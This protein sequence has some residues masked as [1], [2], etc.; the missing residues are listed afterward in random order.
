MLSPYHDH[1]TIDAPPHPMDEI[2]PMV[3]SDR[4]ELR[5]LIEIA[6]RATLPP[7]SFCSVTFL[8]HNYATK[9]PAI[10]QL[11]PFE[12]NFQLH[13]DNG[14]I[15][16]IITESVIAV[17]PLR[18]FTREKTENGKGGRLPMLYNPDAISAHQRIEHIGLVRQTFG[19]TSSLYKHLTKR[20][21]P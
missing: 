16:K 18:T 3:E 14:L 13:T 4:I 12:Q 17:F 6:M 19:A 7:Q 20:R 8:L 5:R 21:S 15:G 2:R 11:I 10:L 9:S 1:L